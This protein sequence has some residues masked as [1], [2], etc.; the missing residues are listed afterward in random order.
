MKDSLKRLLKYITE[1]YSFFFSVTII[2]VVVSALSSV[3]A[4][5]YLS[6]LVDLSLIHI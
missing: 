3:A 1:R 5:A 2:C 6:L 4:Y